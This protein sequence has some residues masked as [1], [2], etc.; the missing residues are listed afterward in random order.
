VSIQVIYTK[1][2]L[3]QYNI[4]A[5]HPTQNLLRFKSALELDLKRLSAAAVLPTKNPPFFCYATTIILGFNK[6]V[7]K[8]AHKK[9]Y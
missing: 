7:N 3:K 1:V 6:V 4:I 5:H 9:E 2:I 8:T